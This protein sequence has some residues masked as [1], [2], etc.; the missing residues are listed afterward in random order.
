MSEPSASPLSDITMRVCWWAMEYARPAMSWVVEG[1]VTSVSDTG[2]VNV[3]PMGPI[4]EA[5]RPDVLIL[6][7]FA[8]SRTLANLRATGQAVFHTVDDVLLLARA[9]IGTL[10]VGQPPAQTEP[11]Q[12]VRGVVLT[13]ACRCQELVVQSLDDRD[14]RVTVTAKIVADRVLRTGLGFCRARHAVVEAAILATRL[15]L[16]GKNPVL[17]DYDR[18]ASCVA[19]TGSATEQQAFDELRQYVSQWQPKTPI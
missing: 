7:P 17:A 5:A 16:T 15:H 11:A 6:R 2:E 4:V 18:L 13:A 3:A 9:A 8:T 19:K 14:Q 1:V 12:Q 10:V